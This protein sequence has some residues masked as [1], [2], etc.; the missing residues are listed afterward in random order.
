MSLIKTKQLQT[1]ATLIF[2]CPT[3]HVFT[4]TL[5]LQKQAMCSVIKQRHDTVLLKLQ[6]HNQI[7]LRD[8]I[9]TILND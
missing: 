2:P 8:R 3:M 5:Y 1:A 7:I 6:L 9:D 4:I